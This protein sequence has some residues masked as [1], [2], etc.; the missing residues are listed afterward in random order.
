MRQKIWTPPPKKNNK[1]NTAN[2]A[3]RCVINHCYK[4]IQKK[5]IKTHHL[6]FLLKEP[7]HKCH[8]IPTNYIEFY[9]L[10]FYSLGKITDCN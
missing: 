10:D 9:K 4:S 3:I 2:V 7:N 6:L 5:Y 1:Y 8:V